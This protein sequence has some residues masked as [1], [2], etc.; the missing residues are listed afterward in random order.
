[1]H[2][3]ILLFKSLHN[4]IFH[5]HG[6]VF[7][8]KECQPGSKYIIQLKSFERVLLFDSHDFTELL[9]KCTTI[10]KKVIQ[11][12]LYTR[13]LEI[14]PVSFF[15]QNNLCEFTTREHILKRLFYT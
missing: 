4:F 11:V 13:N 7:S 10:I 1:M 9:Y 15:L 8:G 12:C 2:R 6:D 5:F 3:K 14:T